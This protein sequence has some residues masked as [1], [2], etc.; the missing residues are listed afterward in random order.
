MKNES[1]LF[2]FSSHTKKRPN[3]LIMGR[4]FD[5]HVLDMFEFGV[6]NV[7]L[8]HEFKN[9]KVTP[10]VKPLIVFSGEAFENEFE[11][12]KLKNYFLDF[13]VGPKADGVR[14]SGLESVIQIVAADNKI[15]FRHFRILLKKSGTRIPRVE[16]DE[17]GPRFDLT[18]RRFKLA[19]HDLYK[20]SMRQPQALRA[21]KVKN[22]NVS[23]LGTTFGRIHMERQDYGKLAVKQ[24]RSMKQSRRNGKTIGERFQDAYG[25][26]AG[27]DDVAQGSGNE[28]VNGQVER[29]VGDKA[30]SGRPQ[31]KGRKRLSD[32]DGERTESRP[33]KKNPSGK[34]PFRNNQRGQNRD[35]RPGKRPA[36]NRSFN[37]RS[38]KKVRQ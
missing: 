22:V 36:G 1:P 30:P 37:N 11:Y 9:Q 8:L 33:F 15:H 14:L 24:V 31:F 17:I 5:G 3:N 19:S 7:K 23:V 38:T 2:V 6:E 35:S 26:V 32:D 29:P 27:R 20:H 28:D 25:P 16:L 18:L 10:G 13:F 4:T 12:M 21:K 34:A